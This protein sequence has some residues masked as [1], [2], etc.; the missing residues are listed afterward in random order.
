MNIGI[1]QLSFATTPYYIDMVDLAQARDVDP[2][3]YLIGIGQDKQA[4]VPPTQD[5]VTLGAT[6]AEKLMTADLKQRISTVLVATESGVDNSKATA[7]YIHHLLDLPAFV[8]VL[9]V[10]QAC[11]GATAALMMARGLVALDPQSVVLVIGS[12]IAR[13]GLKTPGEVTQGAG[14]IAMTVT[15]NPRLLA[16]DHVSVAATADIMDFW[17]PLYAENAMVDGKYSTQVYIDFF[18]QTIRAYQQRTGRSYDDLAAILFHLPFTKMGKKALEALL[19]ERDDQVS[20][21]LREALA[22]SQLYCRN[23]GNLYTGSLYLGLMSYLQ[24]G[25]AVVGSRIGL[26]SYGSGAEG[27]FYSGVLQPGFADQICDVKGDLVKR[28]QVS[29]ADYERMFN[30]QLGLN[31]QDV[32]LDTVNDSSPFILCGQHNHQRQYRRQSL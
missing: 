30:G 21:R 6:A 26:F 8:R 11:Y 12:D 2:N 5:A 19:G 15:A 9:E 16:I 20:Q 18:L 27:E 17:R 29:I 25:Q 31:D 10:K 28:Q 23:V 1:D 4:V 24:N 13:Y 3:K 7:T 14:A 22:A 32:E